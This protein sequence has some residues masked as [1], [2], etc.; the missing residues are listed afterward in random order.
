[1]SRERDPIMFDILLALPP[2][3]AFRAGRDCEGGGGEA[4]R[5]VASIIRHE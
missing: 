2:P 4:V 3:A 5:K 1:V